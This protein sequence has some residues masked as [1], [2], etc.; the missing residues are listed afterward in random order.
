MAKPIPKWVQERLSKLWK[1][2]NGGD[3]T[4]EMIQKILSYDD[5]NTINAFLNELKTADWIDV[6]S[7]EEDLRKKIY[8]LKAPNEV[9]MN[10]KKE[11]K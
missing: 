4:Y 6:K 8:V 2:H 5:K 7:S 11:E 1:K 9:M 3:M 10:V